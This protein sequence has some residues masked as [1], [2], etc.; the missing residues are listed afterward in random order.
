MDSANNAISNYFDATQPGTGFWADATLQLS[1][2]GT[3]QLVQHTE[4]VKA[5]VTI[6]THQT[7]DAHSYQYYPGV[8]FKDIS[9]Y[10]SYG[11]AIYS[12]GNLS[13]PEQ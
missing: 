7:G 12:Y 6:T 4:T 2:D 11:G 9:S 10:S 13:Y 5:A 3:L 1:A 8:E